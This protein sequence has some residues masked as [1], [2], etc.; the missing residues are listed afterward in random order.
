MQKNVVN[1]S[2]YFYKPVERTTTS[3]SVI[4]RFGM[5]VYCGKDSAGNS[6]YDFVNVKMF[7]SLPMGAKEIDVSGRLAVDSWEK[8]GVKH[9]DVYV[10]A[11]NVSP[12]GKEQPKEEIKTFDDEIPWN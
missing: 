12:I 6:K 9:K 2:G 4:T 1:L 3:G 7:G 5:K 11:E 10:L 8:D